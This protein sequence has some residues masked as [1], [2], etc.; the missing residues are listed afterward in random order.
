M[1]ECTNKKTNSLKSVSR[2]IS[3]DTGVPYGLAKEVLS[4]FNRLAYDKLSHGE[5]VKVDGVGTISLRF[6]KGREWRGPRNKEIIVTPD[7]YYL[8]IMASGSLRTALMDLCASGQ[9]PTPKKPRKAP[10]GA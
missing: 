2:E 10:P 6:R 7:S 4:A 3:R 5:S 9:G 1:S 8:S